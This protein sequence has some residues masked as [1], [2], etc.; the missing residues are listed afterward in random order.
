MEFGFT[1]ETVGGHLNFWIDIIKVLFW[2]PGSGVSPYKK[3]QWYRS[4][5]LC[6]QTN[7]L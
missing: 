3:L 7:I 1:P 5:P 4:S 2:P 6:P